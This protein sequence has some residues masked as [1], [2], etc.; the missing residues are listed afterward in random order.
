MSILL[1][2]ALAQADEFLRSRPWT[3]QTTYNTAGAAK[4]EPRCDVRERRRLAQLVELAFRLIRE[5]V[6]VKVAAKGAV[7]AEAGTLASNHSRTTASTICDRS[8]SSRPHMRG[9]KRR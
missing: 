3:I 6:L 9:W 1:A 2:A 8:R 7:R 5:L 4:L